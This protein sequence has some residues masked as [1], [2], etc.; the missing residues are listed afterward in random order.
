MRL[1]N[2]GTAPVDLCKLEAPAEGKVVSASSIKRLRINP[3]ES[4]DVSEAFAS[5][6]GAQSLM[7]SGVLVEEGK[8]SDPEPEKHDEK[9]NDQKR[10]K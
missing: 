4:K 1:R 2:T 3:G 5:T 8:H 6:N 10:K 7:A 9:P